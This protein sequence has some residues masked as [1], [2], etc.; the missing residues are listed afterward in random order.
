MAIYSSILDWRIPRTEVSSWLQSIGLHRIRRDWRNLVWHNKEECFKYH[1]SSVSEDPQ[2]YSVRSFSLA[3]E[4]QN[5]LQG[6]KLSSS[7]QYPRIL[8]SPHACQNRCYETLLFT[9]PMGNKWNL[10]VIW[11]FLIT[12]KMFIDLCGFSPLWMTHSYPLTI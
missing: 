3:V 11:F 6:T 2:G 4:S 10:F 9:N 12:F 8:I 7:Q 5:C 1:H